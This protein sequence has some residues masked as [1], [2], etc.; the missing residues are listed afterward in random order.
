M[1]RYVVGDVIFDA[2]V[3]S[4]D[5][6]VKWFRAPHGKLSANMAQVLKEEALARV[7]HI[8]IAYIMIPWPSET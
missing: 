6:G 8:S 4:V 3:R 1:L 5:P 2:L 7:P